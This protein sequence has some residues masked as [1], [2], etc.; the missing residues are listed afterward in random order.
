MVGLGKALGSTDDGQSVTLGWRRNVVR[1]TLNT[2]RRLTCLPNEH[3]GTSEKMPLLS[4]F[5][6]FVQHWHRECKQRRG[7]N[8]FFDVWRYP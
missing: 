1:V 7:S 6:S 3:S 4:L 2:H 5:Q 8:C